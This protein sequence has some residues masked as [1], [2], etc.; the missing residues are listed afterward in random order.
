MSYTIADVLNKILAA[1]Q[2]TLYYIA[3][4]IASNASVI[5][6]VVVIGG[7]AYGITRYGRRIFGEVVRAFRAFF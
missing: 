7:L 3:D 6:T 1:L 4:A 2:D 5:A